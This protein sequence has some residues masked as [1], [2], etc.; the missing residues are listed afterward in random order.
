MGLY[1]WPLFNIHINDIFL[2]ANNACLCNY[3]DDTTLYSTGENR[4]TNR[5]ILNH[6]FHLYINGLKPR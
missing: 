3:A 5:N 2:S 6:F 4:N 1:I